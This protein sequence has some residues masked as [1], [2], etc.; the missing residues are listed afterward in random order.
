MKKPARPALVLV[1][2]R[3]SPAPLPAALAAVS[4]TGICHGSQPP[5]GAAMA[6]INRLGSK[7]GFWASL[8]FLSFLVLNSADFPSE[9]QDTPIPIAAMLSHPID[10]FSRRRRAR[11]PL[12]PW[13]PPFSA[14]PTPI[15]HFRVPK[16]CQIYDTAGQSAPKRRFAPAGSTLLFSLIFSLFLAISPSA[17]A[18]P[19]LQWAITESSID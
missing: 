18:S 2:R 6:S 19:S 17:K 16:R 12:N 13:C 5:N 7:G 3:D 8:C 1:M 9:P 11:R 15:R 14:A 4:V 10:A